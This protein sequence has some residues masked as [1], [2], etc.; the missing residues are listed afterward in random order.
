MERKND[1]FRQKQ[2]ADVGAHEDTVAAPHGPVV[3]AGDF[4]CGPFGHL[5]MLDTLHQRGFVDALDGHPSQRRTT[6]RNQH[7][8]D[9]VVVR[10]LTVLGGASAESHRPTLPGLGEVGRRRH[11]IRGVGQG[12]KHA[13]C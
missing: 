7:A 11:I 3:V 12:V 8:L 6:V 2:L 9:W 1:A 4:N 5:S 13:L 10:G